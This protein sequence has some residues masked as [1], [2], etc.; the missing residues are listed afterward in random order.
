MK[1]SSA[2]FDMN[3]S[4]AQERHAK[5]FKNDTIHTSNGFMSTLALEI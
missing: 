5:L 3:L 4:N 2:N 1:L